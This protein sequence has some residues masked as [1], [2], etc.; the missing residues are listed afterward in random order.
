VEVVDRDRALEADAALAAHRLLALAERAV[1]AGVRGRAGVDQV[2]IRWTPGLEAPAEDALVE[3]P[4]ALHV[5]AADVE[6]GDVVVCHA[7]TVA[8]SG[9]DD[10]PTFCHKMSPMRQ[11]DG[12]EMLVRTLAV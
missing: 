9:L 1:D 11:G 12:G 2:K 10:L 3:A 6:M 5:V 4:R 8:Y 7:P